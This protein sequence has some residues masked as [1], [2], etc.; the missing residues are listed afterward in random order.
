MTTIAPMHHRE[1]ESLHRVIGDETAVRKFN[2]YVKYANGCPVIEPISIDG[3][4]WWHESTIDRAG[5]Y[6]KILE[7]TGLKLAGAE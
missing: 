4:E 2:Q 1:N 6:R 5:G 3:E 7:M